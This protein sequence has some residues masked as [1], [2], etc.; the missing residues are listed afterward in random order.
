MIR[1]EQ[2]AETLQALMVDRTHDARYVDALLEVR[3]VCVREDVTEPD[4]TAAPAAP[5]TGG[6]D[7]VVR[8]ENIPAGGWIVDS[9]FTI[10]DFPHVP[11]DV[12]ASRPVDGQ[13]MVE[14]ENRSR[15]STVWVK[16]NV[17]KTIQDAHLRPEFEGTFDFGQTQ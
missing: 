15:G 17:F 16:P 6:G 8:F 5:Q 12:V 14:L 9:A 3:G 7:P 10:M 1:R 13:N 4:N 2:I 11:G